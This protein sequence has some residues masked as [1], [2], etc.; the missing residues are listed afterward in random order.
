MG[1]NTKAINRQTGEVIALADKIDLTI[2]NRETFIEDAKQLILKINFLFKE[3]FNKFLWQDLDSLTLDI[4]SGSTKFL[5]D[6]KISTEEFIKYKPQIGDID[7]MIPAESIQ[8]LF[9]LLA[10][11]EFNIIIPEIRYIG[12]NRKSCMYSQINAL[13]KYLDE[14]Y[15]Q[16]DFEAAQFI[17]DK[18][19]DFAKF[20]H[21][22]NWNDIKAGYKGVLHKLLLRNITKAVSIDENMIVLTPAS[23]EIPNDKKWREKKLN[24]APRHLTFSV[25]RG[26]RRKYRLINADLVN[27]KSVYKEIPP[28]ESIYI[29]DLRKI[30]EIIFHVLPNEEELQM[31]ATFRGLV[32]LMKKFLLNKTINIV[33]DY[34]IED[35]LFGENV[36]QISRDNWK[37]DYEVKSK[38]IQKLWREFPELKKKKQETILKMKEFYKNYGK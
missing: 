9:D 22:S 33:Y 26:L 34:L 13:F 20:A 4:F 5:F 28:S 21:N 2:I 8:N 3:K 17:N 12:Q 15:F 27:K 31:F 25:D 16:I 37:E 35:S 11:L 30:F 18:P 29:T 36:Q 14:Y 38:I 23:S 1:G 19:S 10:S 7:I 6:T 24:S 32:D